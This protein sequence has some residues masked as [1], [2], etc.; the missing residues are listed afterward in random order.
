MSKWVAAKK[1][2]PD[3]ILVGTQIDSKEAKEFDLLYFTRRV[4]PS[5]TMMT[6]I[7]T[8]DD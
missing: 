3:Q 1:L 8:D 4:L 7:L 2:K 6:D 5:M